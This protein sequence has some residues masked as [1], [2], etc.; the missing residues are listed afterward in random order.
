M[1]DVTAAPET[2]ATSISE[3]Q[4]ALKELQGVYSYA[5]TEL[6][7]DSG[8]WEEVGNGIDALATSLT[9][10]AAAVPDAALL[11][12]LGRVLRHLDKTCV[13]DELEEAA[14]RLRG[15]LTKMQQGEPA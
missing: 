15:W 10:I 12:D 13:Y 4:A 3:M 2:A 5:A 8:L 6:G 7:H 11:A 1:A 9:R 14:N